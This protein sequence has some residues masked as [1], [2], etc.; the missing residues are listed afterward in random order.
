MSRVRVAAVYRYYNYTSVPKGEPGKEPR[1]CQ[2]NY[3][4]G[5]VRECVCVWMEKRLGCVSHSYRSIY[6]WTFSG[7]SV[8]TR[9]NCMCLYV[10]SHSPLNSFSC[11]I[12][13]SSC[14]NCFSPFRCSSAAELLCLARNIENV[15]MG[16]TLIWWRQVSSRCPQPWVTSEKRFLFG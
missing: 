4:L 5:S 14:L 7:H 12:L 10:F 3:Y 9:A 15:S 2:I 8:Y 1:R 13:N 11:S 6:S 16:V